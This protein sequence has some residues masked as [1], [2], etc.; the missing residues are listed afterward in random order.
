MSYSVCRSGGKMCDGC[1]SCYEEYE[2]DDLDLE[3]EDEE[4]TE[5]VCCDRCGEPLDSDG[6]Y[7]DPYGFKLC[8]L[9]R[10]ELYN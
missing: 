9:C 7:E 4:E 3:D 8:E 6:I 2:D 5:E 10:D 1:M